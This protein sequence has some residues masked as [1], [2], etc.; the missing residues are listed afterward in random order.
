[1]LRKCFP[2]QAGCSWFS[3]DTFRATLRLRG[4]ERNAPGRYAEAFQ[5][6]KLV[7]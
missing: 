4:I 3:D 1:M 7:L 5:T 6:R 2:S